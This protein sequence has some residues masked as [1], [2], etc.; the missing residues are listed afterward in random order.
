MALG[1][2]K[3]LQHILLGPEMN[4]CQSSLTVS[5][6]GCQVTLQINNW[7]LSAR[8]RCVLGADTCTGGCSEK[9]L[10]V[11]AADIRQT[12]SGEDLTG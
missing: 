12:A 4:H 1:E 7:H 2:E 11:F 5:S 8:R 9:L 3:E 10:P 6:A